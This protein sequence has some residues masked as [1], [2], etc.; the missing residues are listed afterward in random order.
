MVKE[1]F[2]E[3]PRYRMTPCARLCRKFFAIPLMDNAILSSAYLCRRAPR[4]SDISCTRG[5]VDTRMDDRW[6]SDLGYGKN[7]KSSGGNGRRENAWLRD[8]EKGLANQYIHSTRLSSFLLLSPNS[9]RAHGHGRSALGIHAFYDAIYMHNVT[10][11]STWEHV[12]SRSRVVPFFCS[13]RQELSLLLVPRRGKIIGNR[14]R[15]KDT[16]SRW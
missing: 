3:G 15:R 11:A 4:K 14:V 6:T 16:R 12:T 8:R 9:I 10:V 7:W 13:P 1:G 5:C 2:A